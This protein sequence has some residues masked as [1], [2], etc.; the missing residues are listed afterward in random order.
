MQDQTANGI[1]APENFLSP[2][3]LS[4]LHLAKKEKKLKEMAATREVKESKDASVEGI[5]CTNGK[6]RDLSEPIESD[7]SDSL[8]QVDMD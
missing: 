2:K 7:H 4:Q 6:C 1:K 3:D 5:Q 8:P